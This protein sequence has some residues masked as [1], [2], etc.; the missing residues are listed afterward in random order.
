MLT[1]WSWEAESELLM[2]RSVGQKNMH[3]AGERLERSLGPLGCVSVPTSASS[4]HSSSP[5][6]GFATSYSMSGRGLDRGL[7]TFRTQTSKSLVLRGTRNTQQAASTGLRHDRAWGGLH[8][9]PLW[10]S[11]CDTWVLHKPDLF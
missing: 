10:L 6:R 11:G 2:E 5:R 1:V 8:T 7:G 9:L 3:Q 4:G